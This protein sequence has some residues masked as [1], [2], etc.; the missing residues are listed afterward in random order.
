MSG[1]QASIST[2]IAK[3]YYYPDGRWDNNIPLYV[4]AVGSHP[5]RISNLYFTFL[6]VLRAVVK[7]GSTLT[8]F[9]FHTGNQEDDTIV[10]NL[11]Q[12]LVEARLPSMGL[13][14]MGLP[15]MGLPS[16]PSKVENSNDLEQC[17]NG[18]DESVLFQVIHCLK[19][20]NYTVSM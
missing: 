16:M 1:L 8:D 11:I 9:P 19:K 12:K 7:A 10:R 13:P 18:F 14:S 3:E 6:F 4:K 15:S 20:A 2:H 17:R 5:D